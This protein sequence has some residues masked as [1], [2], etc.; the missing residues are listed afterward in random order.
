MFSF[1]YPTS[2]VVNV[3]TYTTDDIH[4]IPNFKKLD[5]IVDVFSS[6]QQEAEVQV[7]FH[8]LLTDLCNSSYH[9]KV[10]GK[11]NVQHVRKPLF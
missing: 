6:R 9:N 2:Q 10:D 8:I 1:I 4:Q 3:I 7:I 5:E 11:K